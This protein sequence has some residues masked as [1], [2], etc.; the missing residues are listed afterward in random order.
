MF[1]VAKELNYK[2][3]SP[4]TW[5]I[6]NQETDENIR[7]YYRDSSGETFGTSLDGWTGLIM[8]SPSRLDDLAKRCSCLCSIFLL[9]KIRCFAGDFNGPV[10]VVSKH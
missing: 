5:S 9:T 2:E 7:V 10:V 6:M 1:V 4:S 8:T 3:Y